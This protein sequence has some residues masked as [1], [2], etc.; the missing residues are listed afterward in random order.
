MGNGI[1]LP[2]RITHAVAAPIRRRRQRRRRGGQNN[3]NNN[4][5]P[6][7]I[8]LPPTIESSPEELYLQLFL[9]HDPHAY[10]L[11]EGQT[12]L[13][14]CATAGRLDLVRYLVQERRVAVDAL[15]FAGVTALAQV[16]CVADRHHVVAFLLQQGSN[17]L[18]TL[19]DGSTPLHYLC[20]G[21]CS[22]QVLQQVLSYV[23]KQP[24]NIS[25]TLSTYLTPTEHWT[26][27]HVA[28]QQG[29]V[30]AV[31]SLLACNEAPFVRHLDVPDKQGQTPLL[32]ACRE[33]QVQVVQ[34]L[35]EL[36]QE[37]PYQTDDQEDDHDCRARQPCINTLLCHACRH[38]SLDVVRLLVERYGADPY[39]ATT[40]EEGSVPWHCAVEAQQLNNVYYLLREHNALAYLT[41]CQE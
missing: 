4:N 22:P 29:H 12:A 14:L 9:Q 32:L 13:H 7:L 1:P 19:A 40:N 6:A 28:C 8:Q 24:Q 16:A 11:M 15:N 5:N 31:Q 30:T 38:D 36:Q 34:Y 23:V 33:N 10:E 35:L 3:N 26:P 27:L 20:Q 39:Q 37:Q 18:A 2:Q 41:A 17:P 25:K 21:G